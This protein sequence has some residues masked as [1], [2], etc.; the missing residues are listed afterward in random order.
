MWR[1]LDDGSDAQ[2]RWRHLDFDDSSWTTGPAPLGYGIGD[3]ATLV[4]YG[5]NVHDKFITSYF[6]HEFQVADPAQVLELTL[7]LQ[8]DDGAVVYLNEQEIVRSNMP[9]GEI[10]FQTVASRWVGGNTPQSFN[11]FSIDPQQLRS[12][13]NVLAVEVHQRSAVD[14]DLRF[15]LS[16]EARTGRLS[17]GVPLHPGINRVLVRAFDGPAGTGRT[18]DQ[19]TL[20][21]WYDGATAQ[22]AIAC[23]ALQQD[24]RLAPP[25]LEGGVL[26]HDVVLAPCGPAYRV[27]GEVIVPTGVTLSILPGT[28]VFFHAN[29][30]LT[31]EGGR[32]LAEGLPDAPIRLTRPPETDSSWAGIQFRDSLQDNRLSHAVLEYAITDQGMVG[33][34]GS[35]LTV[36]GVTF[37]HT[38][39]F[40]IRTVNSSLILRNSTF[41]DIFASGQEPTTDNRSE[42]VWGSGI[43]EGGELL[44]EHNWFGTTKGHNDAVDFDGAQRPGP[45]P[46][47]LHNEFAGGGDDAL[48]LETD[49]HVEGNVFRNYTKDIYNGSSGDSNAISAGAGHEYV[50]V[51]NIFYNVDHAAQV[52]DD[53]YMTFSHNTVARTHKAPI[54]FELDE[55]GPGR[56]AYVTDS[57]MYDVPQA[58][59]AVSPTTDLEVHHSI[60]PVDGVPF[61]DGNWTVDPRLVD[62]A[63][64]DFRLG[65]GSPAL[66]SGLDGSDRGAMV[67]SGAHIS[68]EPPRVTGLTTAL[69]QVAGPGL[70]AY[71]YRVNQGPWSES[72]TLARPI[73][74]ANL[75]DGDYTVYVLGQD[76][77]GIWSDESAPV[78]SE[79]WTVAASASLLRIHEVLA[80]NT[81]LAGG[82]QGCPDVVELFNGANRPIDLSGMS[83]TDD[84]ARPLRFVFP[85]GTQLAA[86][87]YLVLAADDVPSS[88]GISLGF[89][90]E[91]SG[92]GVYLFDRPERGGGQLDAVEFGLQLPDLSLSRLG[93]DGHWGLGRPT[94]GAPNEPQPTGDPRALVIN[95]WL[96]VNRTRVPDDFL[97][98]YNRDPLPVELSGLVLTDDPVSHPAR[99][100]IAPLSF[101]SGSGY[102]TFWADGKPSEEADHLDF[103]LAGDHELLAL[104]DSSGHPID[105][106][107]YFHQPSD[108]S[109]GRLPDGGSR[110]G[111]PAFPSPG[112]HNPLANIRHETLVSYD[113]TWAY[114][115]TGIQPDANWT[116]SD[117]DETG[118]SHGPGVFAAGAG[119]LPE[120]VGTQLQTGPLT[121]YFRRHFQ[122]APELL[123]G[124]VQ[125]A[126]E[127][128]TLID[129]G[130]VVYLNGSPVVRLGL[131][132]QVTAQTRAQ[133]GIGVANYEGP[134]VIPSQLLLSGD[135]LLAVEVHQVSAS[136]ADVA[137]G[138][139]LVATVTQVDPFD[140]N[141]ERLLRGLRV[142]EIMYHP[143][144]YEEA[145]YIELCNV[146]DQPLDL[147][148]V[149]LR[150]GVELT[151]P[152]VQLAPGE[153]ALA[154][155]D[156]AVFAQAYD[157]G[158]NIV[159]Q[160]T[161]SLSNRSDELEL[162]LPEPLNVT[163]AR[164][165]Y[166]DAWYPLTDGGG[167]SL[168]AAQTE[169]A[170]PDWSGATAWRWCAG[171][172]ITGNDRH[173]GAAGRCQSRRS[174]D[175]GRCGHAVHR[176]CH[177]PK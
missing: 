91:G 46:R 20:D 33:L 63:R 145:E 146:T 154:V 13:R 125:L 111:F 70:I 24:N 59:A 121:Y 81:Q 170:E 52:K 116:Q 127:L 100:R 92:E 36:D 84:P 60:L 123:S 35:R 4:S 80:I 19:G 10:D 34:E 166:L 32:L 160:Y 155:R 141:V 139:S 14:G 126:V 39:L 174:A 136:S 6:R 31:L 89:R 26:Q 83:L 37:D 104:L 124:G 38:D 95:E 2:R 8:V 138:I 148:G 114:S 75:T 98:L 157:G 43:L 53:A 152:D 129:D 45:I 66:N 110:I 134:F 55:R 54:Y 108:A 68:G 115:T 122:V 161:G 57:I 171:R 76:S 168:V 175:G 71:R 117:F 50:V 151:L 177:R 44:I 163:I 72:R 93:H 119:Q 18:V 140:A 1:Y 23:A 96:S 82:P 5:P 88:L 69:L 133:R 61:G 137:M 172:W 128:Q 173:S 87:S 165:G 143:A 12:G 102:A 40:R 25:I 149:R 58:F 147:T 15:D 9:V 150:G 158:Y 144:E 90:L 67:S 77:A 159:G 109:Q 164:L 79:T 142:T 106:V 22:D 65:P 51:R 130:A 120:P 153:Y 17:G 48:D 27:A 156:R 29:A 167:H 41:T 85:V 62:P 113:S 86:Q 107:A 73:E 47:I 169:M 118:W 135:N 3:E 42:H 105:Q 112:R 49:A 132:E 103:Q 78:A 21:I 131:P 64:G 101:V 74:L 28:S 30:G 99:H 162:L 56:G 16:L 97:E 176:D 11:S 94:P 7:R